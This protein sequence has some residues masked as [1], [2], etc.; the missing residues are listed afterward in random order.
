MHCD[1]IQQ[2]LATGFI[3]PERQDEVSAHLDTCSACRDARLAYAHLD[4]VLS[5]S[6]VWEPPPGFAQR[7]A[8]GA[9]RL[10]QA[11]LQDERRQS[12]VSRIF[13]SVSTI[14]DVATSLVADVGLRMAGPSWVLRQYWALLLNTRN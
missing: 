12:K 3:A 5:R 8:A 2:A 6:P 13:G 14:A 11:R 10:A 1:E 4:E 7:V 9:A